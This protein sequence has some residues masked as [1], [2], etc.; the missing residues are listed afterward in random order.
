MYKNGS[1]TAWC[2]RCTLMMEV[3]MKAVNRSLEIS[4]QVT[5]ADSAVVFVSTNQG[6]S[7][8]NESKSATYHYNNNTRVP[9]NL[10]NVL[11]ANSHSTYKFLFTDIPS[12]SVLL[13]I[14]L[15]CQFEQ[16]VVCYGEAHHTMT[17]RYQPA[18][19]WKL[20]LCP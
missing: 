8:G 1:R 9:D 11:T 15:Y 18:F 12:F 20:F 3:D 14:Y 7:K 17:K 13:F 6:E 5:I 16:N 19:S 2:K 4:S 10:R